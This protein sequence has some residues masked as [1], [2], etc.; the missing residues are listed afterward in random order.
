MEARFLACE[1]DTEI[2]SRVELTEDMID[3][4]WM[5]V[6]RPYLS[7]VP[8]SLDDGVPEPDALSFLSVNFR[9]ETLIG[10]E[11]G[12]PAALYRMVP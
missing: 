9:F 8:F 5:R 10:P 7:P 12:G 1:G 11:D 2:A 4:P 6:C 3:R